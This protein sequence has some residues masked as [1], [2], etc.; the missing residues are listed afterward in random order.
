MLSLLIDSSEDFGKLW[1][2]KANERAGLKFN[3]PFLLAN[4]L[5]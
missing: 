2:L 5:L 4:I 3:T 1:S